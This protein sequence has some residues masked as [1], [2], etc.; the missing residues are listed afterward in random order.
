MILDKYEFTT[1]TEGSTLSLSKNYLTIFGLSLKLK[2]NSSFPP[3]GPVPIET[4]IKLPFGMTCP[5]EKCSISFL[6]PIKCS[7]SAIWR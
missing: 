7:K 6:P 1:S 4:A 2:L 3:V 5:H